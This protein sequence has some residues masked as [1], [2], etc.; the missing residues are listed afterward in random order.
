MHRPSPRAVRH[1]V[2]ALAL[3]TAVMAAPLSVLAH[4][5]LTGSDPKADATLPVS[6]ET[7]TLDFSDDLRP[8][9]H[10][11]VLDDAGRPS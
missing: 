9:S 8:N 4:A 3:V 11:E 10:F 1:V 7:I 6:P 2:A 5:E